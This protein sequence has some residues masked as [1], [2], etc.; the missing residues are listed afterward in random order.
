MTN[1]EIQELIKAFEHI[2]SSNVYSHNIIRKARWKVEELQ[3]Q[4]LPEESKEPEKAG[5]NKWFK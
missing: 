1:D 2:A 4:L 5:I 3:S